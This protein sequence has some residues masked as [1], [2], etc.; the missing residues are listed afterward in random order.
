M[1]IE[2][3]LIGKSTSENLLTGA[4]NSTHFYMACYPKVAYIY[5]EIHREIINNRE[6]IWGIA[7]QTS[8]KLA[9]RL[10][11][12]IK[13]NFI[14]SDTVRNT[15]KAIR[16]KENGLAHATAGTNRNMPWT[17][18]ENDLLAH[19][20]YKINQIIEE[21]PTAPPEPAVIWKPNTFILNNI[22][23]IPD[24]KHQ[25]FVRIPIKAEA[26]DKNFD[27]KN[28]FLSIESRGIKFGDHQSIELGRN[29]IYFIYGFDNEGNRFSR[30]VK[31]ETIGQW[32]KA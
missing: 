24:I 8:P 21:T 3:K 10:A 6:R 14:D 11:N 25:K 7:W 5:E 29:N 30:N 22:K 1:D 2:R 12:N 16:T 9:Q 32:Q 31:G 4:C 17:G 27:V 18:T 28:A 20:E 23:V 15:T 13:N 26:E 19:L